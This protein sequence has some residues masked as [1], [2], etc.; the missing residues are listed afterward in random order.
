MRD[1]VALIAWA[2]TVGLYERID[3]ATIW[4]NP[5][6]V[7]EDGSREECILKYEDYYF[8][9]SSLWPKLESLRGKVLGCW[10]Y[11]ED[12]HGHVLINFLKFDAGNPFEALG[13]GYPIGAAEDYER[14]TEMHSLWAALHYLE[15][16]G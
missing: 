14:F 16:H 8:M 10:C 3:R 12:C 9:K 5:F 2:T 4:G 7:D 13:F 1:D 11:P 6:V 15:E